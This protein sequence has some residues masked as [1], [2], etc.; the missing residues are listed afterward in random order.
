MAVNFTRVGQEVQ[1]NTSTQNAQYRPD[2]AVTTSGR[3]FVAWT[4]DQSIVGD[5]DLYGQF[6][7]PDGTRSGSQVQIDTDGADNAGDDQTSIAVASRPGDGVVV[8]YR[9]TDLNGYSS[10]DISLR[11]IS[12][13]GVV[14]PL[15][16]VGN[17]ISALIAPDVATLA[18]GQSIVVWENDYSGTDHDIEAR[19]LNAAG[20][21]FV[22]GSRA[23]DTSS[24][25]VSEAPAV[26]A[27][28]NNA[29]IVYQDTRG[30]GNADIRATFYNGATNT[31]TGA[32]TVI[33]NASG[34][35]RQPDVA[36][37]T[38]GRYIVV[39]ENEANDDIEGRFVGANGSPIGATFTIANNVGENDDA[40]VAALPGGGFIVTWDTDGG[41]IAPENGGDFAVL[42]R[43]FDNT[44]AAAGDL[45][46]VNTGDPNTGQFSPA[47]AVNPGTGRA[48]IAWE[49]HH[50]F[51]GAGQD[52]DPA[53]VRGRAFLVTTDVV[54]GTPGNDTITTYS[55]S[56]PINGLAG[57]DTINARGGNDA[58]DG[59]PGSDLLFG[60]IGN[61][62]VA[63]GD[64]ADT[65]KGEDGN[66]LIN[67]GLGNDSLTGGPGADRFVFNTAIKPKGSNIDTI[68]DFSVTDDLIL[69]DNAI[70]KK[71]KTEG[72]LKAKFFEVGKKAKSGKDAII[73]NDKTGDLLYD[74]NGA[75]KGGAILFAKLEGSPD[76][77]SAADFLVI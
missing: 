33:A 66:D 73:Y 49:D 17:L 40:R 46:L 34:N 26:A 59:G 41:V 32:A 13:T 74:K 44:G 65:V 43:R 39:W 69:L 21:G 9:D 67:G 27:S 4:S 53:G 19:F 51:S 37:L 70:F 48:F 12:S 62:T 30:G 68:A 52:N 16:P 7:N 61:D 71:L 60:G 72:V 56:E 29:L 36:A 50:S 54:N 28:G 76:D 8:V 42:A 22:T 14:G 63:G 77:V 1:V 25:S 47:I 57:N 58:V 3:F 55:L 35:L 11:T 31:F 20:T 75:K 10:S 2:V 24:N 45:L 64:G 5:L 18:N 23:V 6:F 15:L 38:D